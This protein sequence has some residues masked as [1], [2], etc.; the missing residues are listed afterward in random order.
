MMDCLTIV[1]VSVFNLQR[2]VIMSTVVTAQSFHSSALMV[3]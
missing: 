1:V 2:L 3:R